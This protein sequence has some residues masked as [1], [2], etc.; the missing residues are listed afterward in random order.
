M[1]RN[2]YR[3]LKYI[4]K[5]DGSVLYQKVSDKFSKHVNPSIE[6]TIHWLHCQKFIDIGY[7][8]E[9]DIGDLMIPD[10]ILSTIEGKNVVEERL[11]RNN[12]DMFARAT[13]ILAIL[14]SIASIIISVLLR[15]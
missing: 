13:A 3:V 10:K 15:K 5:C 11:S 12:S 4:N 14:L 8:Y 2:S 7:S 9:N 6:D 1:D